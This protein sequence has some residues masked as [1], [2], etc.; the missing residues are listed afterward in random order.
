MPKQKLSLQFKLSGRQAA[1]SYY[2]IGVQS[3]PYPVVPTICIFPYLLYGLAKSAFYTISPGFSSPNNQ[4]RPVLAHV[5]PLADQRKEGQTAARCPW[6]A[7]GNFSPAE[8]TSCACSRPTSVLFCLPCRRLFDPP[9]PNTVIVQF[10]RRIPFTK[11]ST[12]YTCLMPLR[13][14][15]LLRIIFLQN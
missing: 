15:H 1:L 3:P 9:K 8:T 10:Y 12:F 6:L 13:F 4:R 11:R 5:C 7:H 14:L 2:I